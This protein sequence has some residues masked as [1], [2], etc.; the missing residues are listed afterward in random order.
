MHGP[1]GM[2]GKAKD[3][4]SLGDG[5][6]KNLLERAFG[7]PTELARVLTQAREVSNNLDLFDLA[8]CRTR[9]T[10]GSDASEA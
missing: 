7:V 9:G 10:N 4:E 1:R 6:L 8:L 2:F 3:L 5:C